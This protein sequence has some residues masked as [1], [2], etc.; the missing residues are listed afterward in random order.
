MVWATAI[1]RSEVVRKFETSQYPILGIHNKSRTADAARLY[2]LKDLLAD[3]KSSAFRQYLIQDAF[4]FFC[5]YL[6][7]FFYLL[8]T[9]EHIAQLMNPLP[10]QKRR[11]NHTPV[12]TRAMK[13]N[14]L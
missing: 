2:N 13:L 3:C 14:T 7:F 10:L 6:F 8:P 4:F 11:G 5:F 1:N 12:T 9:T